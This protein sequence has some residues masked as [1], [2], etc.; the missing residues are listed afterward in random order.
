MF[1]NN[2]LFYYSTR[3]T[4][5][6]VVKLIYHSLRAAQKESP[7]WGIDERHAER[8]CV[9]SAPNADVLVERFTPADWRAPISASGTKRPSRWQSSEDTFHNENYAEYSHR[10]YSHFL[11][12]L[13]S[14]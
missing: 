4:Q 10:A 2:L 8:I 1:P 13:A 11:L 14:E 3:S 7:L 12:T 6:S 9:P 5:Q